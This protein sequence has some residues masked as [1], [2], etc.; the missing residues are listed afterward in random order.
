MMCAASQVADIAECDHYASMLADD[1]S[2]CGM[3]DVETGEPGLF[4]N[5]VLRQGEGRREEG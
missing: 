4:L 2:S 5:Q 1:L 3:R